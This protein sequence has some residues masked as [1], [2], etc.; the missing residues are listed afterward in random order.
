M[1]RHPPVHGPRWLIVA[2]LGALVVTTAGC[3]SPASPGAANT[4]TSVPALTGVTTSPASLAAAR[5]EWVKGSKVPSYVQPI[6]L[7]SA[8]L[9]LA[10]AVSFG[11][12]HS[13]NEKVAEG[14]LLQLASLPATSATA[15]QKS[16]ASSDLRA[17][18]TFFNT[19][20]LYE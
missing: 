4:T 2:G 7:R 14:Q 19:S 13:S 9:S 15:H 10:V 11:G 6:Y 17:L 12:P 5:V 8:A 20:R 1:K 18:N 16:E 3:G